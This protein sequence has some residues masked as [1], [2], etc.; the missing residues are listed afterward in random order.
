MLATAWSNGSPRRSGAGY[1]L[2]ISRQDRDRFFDQ[3]WSTVVIHLPEQDP[4][5]VPLSESFW[6]SCTELRSA[7]IG[8]WLLLNGL[9]PW[10]RGKPPV[11][12]LQSRVTETSVLQLSCKPEARLLSAR[13]RHPHLAAVRAGRVT[14]APAWAGAVVPP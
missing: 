14:S 7:A 2:K 1:G 6:R 12:E 11:I 8:R 4:T 3:S 5:S 13:N 10:P 9:A